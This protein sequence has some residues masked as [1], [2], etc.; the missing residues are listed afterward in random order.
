[1]KLMR[2]TTV[3]ISQLVLRPN[4]LLFGRH[5]GLTPAVNQ[6]EGEAHHYHIEC[7]LRVEWSYTFTAIYVYSMDR[8]SFY[9][10]AVLPSYT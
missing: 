9:C 1:M 4:I 2:H 10:A 7:G 3:T 8:E 5:L 6:L